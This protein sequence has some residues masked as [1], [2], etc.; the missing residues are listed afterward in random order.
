M[1]GF[2]AVL[3]AKC[4]PPKSDDLDVALFADENPAADEDHRLSSFGSSFISCTGSAANSIQN[5][6]PNSMPIIGTAPSNVSTGGLNVSR[7]MSGE[8]ISGDEDG[9][10]SELFKRA[11][12]VVGTGRY[13]APEMVVLME[14]LGFAGCSG[15]TEAVDWWALGVLM[16]KLLTN[17]MPFCADATA[18]GVPRWTDLIGEVDFGL[19]DSGPDKFAAEDLLRQLLTVDETKRLG[20]GGE[21]GSVNVARHEYFKSID[22]AQLELKN[23]DPPPVPA[24][25]VTRA[26]SRSGTTTPR[27]RGTTPRNGLGGG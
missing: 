24:C 3:V 9:G 10:G 23:V 14:G 2:V 6:N 11:Y 7:S 5:P 22:W 15:Y 12:S 27:S 4:N 13:M 17:V 16:F 21:N 18:P 1:Y 26:S 20:F 8:D 25:V 19:L